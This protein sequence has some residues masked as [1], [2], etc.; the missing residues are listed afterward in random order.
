M[1]KEKGS[2]PPSEDG[3][4]QKLTFVQ[5]YFYRTTN[6][7]AD[8]GQEPQARRF[9]FRSR[10]FLVAAGA[11]FL[12]VM[13]I[14]WAVLATVYERHRRAKDTLQHP[15]PITEAIIA[16]FPDPTIVQ[17]NGTWY[18]FATNNAAGILEQPNNQ[19]SYEYGRSN[20]QL[21]VSDDFDK[22]TLL[23]Y[24]HDPLP[25]AGDWANRNITNTT[26]GPVSRSNVWAP[27][28]LQ[29]PS[30]GKFVLYYAAAAK[31]RGRTHCVGAAVSNTSS[32]AGPYIPLDTPLA[33][34]VDK[35]GAIDP[36]PY[37]DTDG[38]I[39][40]AWKVDGNNIGHGGSCGN[41]VP[42]LV[43][44]PIM[45]QKMKEDGT[46]ADGE[47]IQILDRDDSD[48]PLVEAPAFA[49]TD[50]GRYFLFFSSGCTR[51]PSYDVKYAY[52]DNITG[53]YTRAQYPLLKTGDWGLLA[54]GS[55]DIARTD[56]GTY[57]MA[58]HARVFTT[59]GRV[60]AMFTTRIEFDGG[61]VNMIR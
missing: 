30:D 29:R 10:G 24:T 7:G 20:V 32:P 12:L 43:P 21:A 36:A 55:V 48:G 17:H 3:S 45:L 26:E 54:P 22:W 61:L 13:V 39:Y 25:T 37:I 31:D 18:A 1:T 38:S 52:A 44:T 27:A 14:L 46:T 9:S 35:G 42:P 6:D 11:F 41:T 5:R 60:R 23:N 33:C 16:N 50:D 57:E 15:S 56:N 19:S 47:A 4:Q 34:P 53:P 2:A 49:R 59:F 58:F 28:I 8:E 40:V 51:N